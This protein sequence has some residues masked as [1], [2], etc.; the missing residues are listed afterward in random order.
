M[1][2]AREGLHHG[3]EGRPLGRKGQADG[4]LPKSPR[5]AEW[6]HSGAAALPSRQLRTAPC[7][8]LWHKR[9]RGPKGEAA[10]GYQSAMVPA[11]SSPEGGVRGHRQGPHNEGPR[12]QYEVSPP[13]RPLPPP[14][15]PHT[16]ESDS[17]SLEDML[18]STFNTSSLPL[19]QE[20]LVS[21]GVLQRLPGRMCSL[22][23]KY[24][25]GGCPRPPQCYHP[26]WG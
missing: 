17:V 4:E 20:L 6:P 23:V 15:S 18:Q 5:Q 2:L 26:H 19:T 13:P 12:K 21:K 14:P 16:L 3:I 7:T 24:S 25:R 10:G 11:A 8:W 1:A 22:L 9:Q